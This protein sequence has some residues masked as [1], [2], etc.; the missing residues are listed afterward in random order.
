MNVLLMQ[1]RPF[2][3]AA[4]QLFLKE[5][6]FDLVVSDTTIQAGE[7]VNKVRPCVIIA[8]ITSGVCFDVISKAK[9][10]NIPVMV[11]SVNGKEDELQAA[12][13]FGADDYMC[14]PLTL[15]ELALRVMLLSKSKKPALA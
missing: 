6:G 2:M 3:P 8:D 14:L 5:K 1:D 9:S 7:M 11:L 13:D 12:F 15:Q 4:M 10:Q